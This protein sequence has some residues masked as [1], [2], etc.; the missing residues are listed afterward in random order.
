MSPT[1]LDRRSLLK[2]ACATSSLAVFGTAGVSAQ[3][4]RSTDQLG[5]REG[6]GGNQKENEDRNEDE[7]VLNELVVDTDGRPDLEHASITFLRRGRTEVVR[8][9]IRVRHELDAPDSHSDDE[10][11]AVD[12]SLSLDP[13]LRRQGRDTDLDTLDVESITELEADAVVLERSAR[14]VELDDHF[15]EAALGPDPDSDFDSDAD[16]DSGSAL[17]LTRE[18]QSGTHGLAD[19]PAFDHLGDAVTYVETSSSECG[20]L[21]RTN[22]VVDVDRSNSSEYEIEDSVGRFETVDG[23]ACDGDEFGDRFSCLAIPAVYDCSIPDAF[24]TTWHTAGSDVDQTSV[25]ADYYNTD[26]PV[27]PRTTAD[28]SQETNLSGTTLEVTGRWEHSGTYG[29]RTAIRYLLKGSVGAMYY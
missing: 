14:T 10:F 6:E 27:V 16:S 13:T 12:H 29:F 18:T 28:H 4:R 8:G 24:D 21:C 15:G 17:A 11:R 20:P 22:L 7:D 2:H 1:E 25:E 26:F 19:D 9:E 3:A 23:S 5:E